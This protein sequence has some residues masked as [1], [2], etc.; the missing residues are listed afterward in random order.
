MRELLMRGLER[1]I[2]AQ[3]RKVAGDR[4]RVEAAIADLPGRAARALASPPGLLVSF[5]LGAAAAG[6]PRA[7]GL[8][9]LLLWDL[10]R[11]APLEDLPVVGEWIRELRGHANPPAG[12]A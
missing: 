5:S 10:L 4:R 9:T 1:E 11:Q 3:R 12:Q 6:L 8:A 7:H 2:R